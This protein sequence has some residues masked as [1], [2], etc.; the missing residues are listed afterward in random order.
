LINT[1]GDFIL[2]RRDHYYSYNLATGID[3][4]EQKITEVVRGMDLLDCT[5]AQI[6]VQHALNLPTP[7]YCHLPVAINKQG[8]KLSKQNLA[9]P[10]L[11]TDSID[12]LIKALKFLGQMPPQDLCNTSQEDIWSWAISN[13]KI[14]SVPK[15]PAQ[16]I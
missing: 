15:A 4:T 10:I 11:K 5:P 9:A 1:A 3:D 8:Q 14:E 12:L 13:W 2:Q 16:I 6:E 7:Q